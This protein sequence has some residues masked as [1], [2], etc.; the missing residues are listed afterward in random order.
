M[1][2]VKSGFG[3]VL[4]FMVLLGVVYL[5]TLGVYGLLTAVGGLVV[6][7]CTGLAQKLGNLFVPVAVGL[8]VILVLTVMFQTLMD[9][10]FVF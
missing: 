6:F 1:N 8:P 5:T 2:I 3:I 4:S 10:N 7:S 9:V